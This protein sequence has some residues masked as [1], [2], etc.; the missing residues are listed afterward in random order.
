MERFMFLY[1]ELQKIAQTLTILDTYQS[2]AKTEEEKV[3]NA[4]YREHLERGR[5]YLKYELER[6]IPK[7]LTDPIEIV[8]WVAENKSSY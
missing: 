3:K 4:E 8:A 7:H 6:A 5:D 1:R 2:S